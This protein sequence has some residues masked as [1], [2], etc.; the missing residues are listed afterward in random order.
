MLKYKHRSKIEIKGVDGMILADKIIK[1]RKENNWSQEELAEKMGVSRQAVSKWE[2]AQAVPELSKVLLMAQ[3]FGVTT[4][5]LLKDEIETAEHVFD[6][7]AG[8]NARVVTLQDANRY[9]ESR[10]KASFNIAIATFMCVISP[11]AL[12]VL[13]GVS[14]YTKHISENVAA[15]LGLT[16]LF[17]LVGAA[18]AIYIYA[19]F[20]NEE[21]KFL[22]EESFECEYGVDGMVNERIRKYRD[23]YIRG[24]IIATVMCIFSVL[25]LIVAATLENELLCVCMTGLLMLICAFAVYIYISVGVKWASLQRLHKNPEYTADAEKNGNLKSTVNTIYWAVATAIYFLWSFTTHDWHISWIVWV[26]AGVFDPIV[27]LIC[28]NISKSDK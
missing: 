7:D 4:D 22:E 3:L 18:V 12:I 17:F 1:Q 15:L 5:Y 23:T 20:K 26:L 19:G 2:S 10:K 21:F 9:I 11:I 16:I 6:S 24:N 8:S 28:D 27:N 13:A 14:E 25:P